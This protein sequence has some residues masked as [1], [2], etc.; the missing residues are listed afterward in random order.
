MTESLTPAHLHGSIVVAVDGSEDA[1]R[2]VRWAA[3]QAKLENRRLVVVSV[4]T[5]SE[6]LVD[7]ARALAR[8]AG[9]EETVLGASVSGDPRQVLI[10]ASNDAHLLVLGSRGRGTVR[11]MLLGSVSSTVS[12]HAAC[13]VVVCRPTAPGEV[14]AGVVVGADATPQS[15]PVLE[16]AYRQ[17]SERGL[18]L[19]VLHAYW[20]AAAAIEAHY[21]LAA[22]RAERPNLEDLREVLSESTAGLSE[23]YPDVPVSVSLQHGLADEA[24]S[25]REGGWDLVVVGRHSM[26]TVERLLTG[27]IARAVLERAHGPVAVVPVG[28]RSS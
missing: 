10:D 20:D 6:A 17:A 14:R 21:Q 7:E 9:P 22:T 26:T 8:Q 23:V 3:E 24:L 19:T 28:P 11:S 5:G 18:P 25:P 15:R 2:A 4:G 1:E 12:A 16:F 13:P 27:S